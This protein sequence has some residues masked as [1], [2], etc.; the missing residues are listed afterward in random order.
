V[1]SPTQ[2]RPLPDNTQHS[3]HTDIYALSGIRIRNPSIRAAS[4]CTATV[5]AVHGVTPIF[6]RSSLTSFSHITFCLSS[7]PRPYLIHRPL[8]R[9]ADQYLETQVLYKLRGS[10]SFVRNHF[11]IFIQGVLSHA[12]N[13]L[14]PEFFLILAHPVYKM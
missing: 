2:Q 7:S 3:Q 11:H 8:L 5:P 6:L 13:P 4:D 1:I 10:L 9:H 14:A 12:I